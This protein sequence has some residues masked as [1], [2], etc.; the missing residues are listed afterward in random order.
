MIDIIWKIVEV[1]N[2]R[3][4][5]IVDYTSDGDTLRLGVAI[6]EEDPERIIAAAAP[7]R[8]FQKLVDRRTNGVPNLSA[9][10]GMSGSVQIDTTPIALPNLV[11]RPPSGGTG[12]VVS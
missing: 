4:Q 8:Y 3:R 9:L 11:V 7:L 12:T 2:E 10:V 6:E 5:L 1:D